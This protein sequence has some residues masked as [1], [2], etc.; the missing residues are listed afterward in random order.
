MQLVFCCRGK[1]LKGK[2][3]AIAEVELRSSF[4][5]P[6]AVSEVAT[7]V[8]VTR[9]ATTSFELRCICAVRTSGHLLFFS[10]YAS[11]APPACAAPAPVVEH[12]SR[13]PAA[14][15]IAPAP[16]G[17]AASAPVV[18]CI[19]AAAVSYV[20]PRVVYVAPAFLVKYICPTQAL[21]YATPASVVEYIS[22]AAPT[23]SCST[24]AHTLLAVPAPVEA[25]LQCQRL[26][27]SRQFL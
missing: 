26:A 23:M 21:S 18:V 12:I 22:P 9:D 27:T 19:S 2:F 11:P 17:Y 6:S 1:F 24:P 13:A 8:G 15:S 10:S 3:V 20:G 16:A 25:Y 7:T 4:V 14:R 5:A